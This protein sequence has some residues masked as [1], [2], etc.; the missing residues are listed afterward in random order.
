[1]GFM[2]SD[3]IM[4]ARVTQNGLD[5]NIINKNL[6]SGSLISF[7]TIFLSLKVYLKFNIIINF[8]TNNVKIYI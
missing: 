4:V 1:M 6:I 7:D 2:L 5:R 3:T 8:F